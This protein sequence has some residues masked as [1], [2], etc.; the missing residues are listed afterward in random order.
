MI[1]Q[2]TRK[3]GGRPRK[4][5][6]KRGKNGRLIRSLEP[7]VTPEFM[8]KRAALVGEA[9]A[10]SETPGRASALLNHWGIIDERQAL[11][12][13]KYRSALMEYRYRH[14]VPKSAAKTAAIETA[15]EPCPEAEAPETSCAAPDQDDEASAK[16]AKIRMDQLRRAIE[17]AV[18]FPVLARE[19]LEMFAVLDITPPA[20]RSRD[21]GRAAL[22]TL[23]D[24][25]NAIADYFGLAKGEKTV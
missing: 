17:D 7:V 10:M 1:K 3:K 9:L 16:K 18:Q 5:D 25:T 2:K 21:V 15:F 23:L 24:A 14:L 13:E 11:A 20:W 22:F 6:A 4:L 19:L 12:L 8:A